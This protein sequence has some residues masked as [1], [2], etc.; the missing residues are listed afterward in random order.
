MRGGEENIKFFLRCF[1]IFSVALA[2]L[3][4]G[5]RLFAPQAAAVAEE[6]QKQGTINSAHS[7]PREE[8]QAKAAARESVEKEKSEEGEKYQETPVLLVQYCTS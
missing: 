3:Q 7:A 4:E 8:R 1:I 5:M 6:A 2:G